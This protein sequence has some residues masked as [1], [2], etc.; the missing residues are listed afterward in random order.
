MKLALGLLA[1]SLYA[2]TLPP[3]WPNAVATNNNL[4][5]AGNGATA[6]LAAPITTT[7]GLS[8]TITS[9]TSFAANMV[10]QVD[11]EQMLICT[12]SYPTVTICSGGRGFGG[13][14]AATH[15]VTHVVA[16]YV[17]SQYHNG[18]STELQA[19]E[20]W[21]NGYT[22]PNATTA[23]PLVDQL[24]AQIQND[25]RN[26]GA[27]GVVAPSSQGCSSS[28]VDDKTAIQLALT[29]AST[30][31][32]PDVYLPIGYCWPIQTHIWVPPGVHFHSIGRTSGYEQSSATGAV[33]LAN[34]NW[35]ATNTTF[36][37]SQMVWNSGSDCTSGTC[38]FSGVTFASEIDHLEI[39]CND[40]V[41]CGNL[42]GIGRQEKSTFH[43]LLLTG[44]VPFGSG[45][46]SHAWFEQGVDC[47]G[48]SPG[49]DGC[50]LNES[51][52]AG[53]GPAGPDYNIEVYPSYNNCQANVVPI[54]LQGLNGYKGLSS[55][56]VGGVCGL[57]PYAGYVWGSSF[58]LGTN[59]LMHDETTTNG[60]YIG[61]DPAGTGCNGANNALFE[62]FEH[63]ITIAHCGA[64]Y[65][66][67]FINASGGVINNQAT[68]PYTTS[69]LDHYFDS[70]P[71]QTYGWPGISYPAFSES[72]LTYS[73]PGAINFVG[74]NGISLYATTPHAGLNE[75]FLL[76]TGSIYMR[77]SLCSDGWWNTSTQLWNVGSNGAGDVSCWVAGNGWNGLV[78][79]PG[80]VNTTI[81]QTTLNNNVAMATNTSGHTVV[82]KGIID[83]GSGALLDDGNT[84]Q[85]GGGISIGVIGGTRPTWKTG[86]GNPAGGCTKGS[87][88]S[89][90]SGG[91]LWFC[92][93]SGWSAVTI[94]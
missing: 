43:D 31:G 5:V 54:S 37:Y 52:Q 35:A 88:Y 73:D 62:N 36:P 89:D 64:Q 46:Y 60:W 77:A 34:A 26:W 74:H 47:G 51:G 50:L 76:D 7:T 49:V 11:N 63:A 84:L 80:T 6:T 28:T 67:T 78:A 14:T 71:P 72:T 82:G 2:Q 90:Y 42:L 15:L 53:T 65:A 81:S 38:T 69:S 9:P 44:S 56:T 79:Y 21:L 66:L 58:S 93:S 68:V 10:V 57:I 61:S 55:I 25:P 39:N 70:G 19:V 41:G 30:Y 83:N 12:Y 92:T 17:F 59:G 85:V 4:L 32:P 20:S 40:Q 87:I 75:Q 3:I 1:A 94:P 48:Y 29:A 13:T 24:L 33:L 45:G 22:P 86:S 91:A 18:L 16:N 23:L 8:F 27:V